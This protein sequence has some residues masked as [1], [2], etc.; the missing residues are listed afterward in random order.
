M[1]IV[2]I[3]GSHKQKPGFTALLLDEL[4]EGARAAGAEVESLAL[5]RLGVKPCI[6]CSACQRGDLGRCAI[7]GEDGAE[8]AFAAIR[9]ADLVVFASPV[10]VFAPSSLLKSFLERIYALGR[11]SDFLVSRG[12]LLFHEVEPAV[13]A[14][15]FAIVITSD[16][17][18]HET[19]IGSERYFQTFSRFMDAP[20]VG[21]LVR[22]GGRRIREGKAAVRLDE[23]RAVFRRA[24]EEL[25]REGRVSRRTE[26][27]ARK[28]ALPVP[29]FLLT[30][31]KAT[32]GGRKALIARAKG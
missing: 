22:N 5:A 17:M 1:R 27:A 20:I 19:T 30:L 24:G 12:G 16:N 29:G 4:A 32:P 2:I 8:L 9:R 7:S 21:S 11:E 13:G 26:R 28:R 3:N 6:A 25:A 10:Y 31:L 14:K 23:V 15:P 18:E